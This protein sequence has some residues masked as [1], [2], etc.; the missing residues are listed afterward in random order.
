MPTELRDHPRWALLAVPTKIFRVRFWVGSWG[1]RT[2]TKL[3]IL[4]NSRAVRIFQ[5]SLQARLVKK[6]RKVFVKASAK[7]RHVGSRG[8]NIV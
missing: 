1:H 3:R 8:R 2:P 6:Q 7:K 5:L 4:S